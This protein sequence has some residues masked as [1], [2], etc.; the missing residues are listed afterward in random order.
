MYPIYTSSQQP[1]IK[2]VESS[3]NE[4]LP[5]QRVED[6]VSHC[7]TLQLISDVQRLI[8]ERQY[9]TIDSTDPL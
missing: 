1:D 4:Y 7:S 6:F 9:I 5:V 3:I 8:A 2:T